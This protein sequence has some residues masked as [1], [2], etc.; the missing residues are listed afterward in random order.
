MMNI[1]SP[2]Q[3]TTPPPKPRRPSPSDTTLFRCNRRFSLLAEGPHAT[4]LRQGMEDWKVLCRNGEAE[5][6]TA[7]ARIWLR[8]GRVLVGRAVSKDGKFGDVPATQRISVGHSTMWS[9]RDRAVP[10]FM[11]D[12]TVPREEP[13]ILL[14]MRSARLWVNGTPIKA[15][16]VHLLREGDRLTFPNHVTLSLTCHPL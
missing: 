4:W 16:Q 5:D 1:V 8:P 11:C 13:Y 12:L 15:D 3:D 10:R 7:F 2:L 9:S 6:G 14:Y